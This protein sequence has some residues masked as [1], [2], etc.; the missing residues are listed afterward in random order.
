MKKII[1]LL[2][3]TIGLCLTT[4]ISANE[5]STI[6]G[7]LNENEEKQLYEFFIENGVTQKKA[8]ELVLKYDG[9]ELLDSLKKEYAD[10]KPSEIIDT[11]N[12]YTEKYIYPDGSIK[13]LRI[14]NSKA[15]KSYIEPRSIH[16]GTSHNYGY[17]W[18]VTKAKAEEN[19]GIANAYFLLDY[20]KASGAHAQIDKVYT[21]DNSWSIITIGGTYSNVDIF[22][23]RKVEGGTSITNAEADL[24]FDFTAY[25]GV[26]K[27]K[28]TLRAF[29]GDDTTYTTMYAG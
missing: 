26:A 6:D 11:E 21:D 20:S 27:F 7:L 22:I 25:K 8:N 29:V 10:Q 3:L 9:G 5:S 17:A 4:P 23:A 12:E 1:S 16:G 28:V 15:H 18:T 13:I 2:A 14:D 19:T 24:V